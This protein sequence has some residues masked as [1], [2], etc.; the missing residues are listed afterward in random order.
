MP[1]RTVVLSFLAIV[2]L[3]SC[4][5]NRIFEKHSSAFPQFR[6]QQGQELSFSPSIEDTAATYSITLAMRHVNGFQFAELKAN[7]VVTSPSGNEQ[8]MSYTIPVMDGKGGYH[9]ECALDLCDLE[10]VVESNWQFAESGTYTFRIDHDMPVAT[11]P[12]VMEVGLII[13]KHK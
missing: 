4:D 9:S 13:D 1:L 7:M 8:A 2:A 5:E 12:N 11:L 10:H 3:C 6:W